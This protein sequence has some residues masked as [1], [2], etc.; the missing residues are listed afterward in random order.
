MFNRAALFSE[1]RVFLIQ[2]DKMKHFPVLYIYISLKHIDIDGSAIGAVHNQH[3]G[4]CIDRIFLK[5]HNAY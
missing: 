4:R 5:I 1:E 2:T 3:G